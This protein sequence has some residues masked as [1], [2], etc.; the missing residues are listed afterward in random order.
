MEL[1]G[2][3]EDSFHEGIDSREDAAPAML[4]SFQAHEPATLRPAFPLS[5]PF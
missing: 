5:L 2:L 3:E 1:E 4:S